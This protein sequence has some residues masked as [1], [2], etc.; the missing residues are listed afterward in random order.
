LPTAAAVR[1]VVVDFPS[2]LL[3]RTERAVAELHTNRSALIRVA[4]EK[5]LEF[6]QKA[7]LEQALAEGYAAN[8]AQ[9]RKS[10]E[11]FAHVDSDVA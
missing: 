3:S 9:A 11:E 10:C 1:R 4:V 8:A 5:Y 2:P 6:L 7:K